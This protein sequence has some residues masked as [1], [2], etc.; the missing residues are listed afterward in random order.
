M[1]GCRGQDEVPQMGREN[2][3]GRESRIVKG[4]GVHPS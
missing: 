2:E 3:G 1:S 4:K